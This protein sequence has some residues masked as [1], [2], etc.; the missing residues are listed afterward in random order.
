MSDQTKITVEPHRATVIVI[1]GRLQARATSERIQL[2]V[3]KPVEGVD[4]TLTLLGD[5]LSVEIDLHS[6]DIMALIEGL[7]RLVR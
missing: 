2:Q 5:G 4:G 7:R 6:A 1:D 3:I